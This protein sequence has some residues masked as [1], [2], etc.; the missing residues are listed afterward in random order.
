MPEIARQFNESKR[1][2]LRGVGPKPRDAAV[3]ATVVDQ[4][5][6]RLN[7][8]QCPEDGIKACGQLGKQC[9]FVVHRDDNV[10]TY[11]DREM[12]EKRCKPRRLGMLFWSV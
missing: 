6:N 12:G 5:D 10:Q 11:H 8:L 9:F 3:V 1:R 2:V 4:S 7:T